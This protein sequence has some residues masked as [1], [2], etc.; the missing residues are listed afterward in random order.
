MHAEICVHKHWDALYD[1][2]YG[3]TRELVERAVGPDR[4]E[5]P[6]EEQVRR[7]VEYLADGFFG[8]KGWRVRKHYR[9][10]KSAET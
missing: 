3:I 4:E 10:L 6:E 8:E 7:V 5:I 9:R 2:R 1:E